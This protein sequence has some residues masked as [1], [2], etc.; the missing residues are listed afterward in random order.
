MI[1]RHPVTG[2]RLLF[3][4]PIF[5]DHLVG[6]EREE[7]DAILGQLY[8]HCANPAFNV[9]FRWE[10]HSVALWD[11]RCTH[12]LALWDYYPNTRSGFRIQIEGTDRVI[13]G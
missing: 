6:V 12:H 5:T 11:N 4:N 7:S 9:R 10:P 2:R 13:P 8:R 1:A 3:V